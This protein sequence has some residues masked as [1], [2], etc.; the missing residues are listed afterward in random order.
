[1]GV[2]YQ[3]PKF[4]N[5]KLKSTNSIKLFIL[6]IFSRVYFIWKNIDFIIEL[7]KELFKMV[8]LTSGYELVRVR[9]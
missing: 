9:I 6:I 2:G 3:L 1:M 8:N 7:K 4:L 5:I